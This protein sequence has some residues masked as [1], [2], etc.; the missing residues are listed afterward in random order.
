MMAARS[1]RR[2]ISTSSASFCV[3]K[4]RQGGIELNEESRASQKA[5]IVFH[6]GMDLDVTKMPV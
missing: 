5:G 6:E 1:R 3:Q 2:A 4:L